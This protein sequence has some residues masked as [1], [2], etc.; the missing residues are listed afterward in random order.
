[1]ILEFV[2]GI[3]GICLGALL[4]FAYYNRKCGGWLKL[5]AGRTVILSVDPDNYGKFFE[6]KKIMPDGYL[7]L[8]D[9]SGIIKIDANTGIWLGDMD[10]KLYLHYGNFFRTVPPKVAAFSTFFKG[11]K[12]ELL[13]MTQEESDTL[14]RQAEN[15]PESIIF[16]L[17]DVMDWVHAIT[18][19]QLLEGALAAGRRYMGAK[20][21]E[22]SLES[23]KGM[24][25]LMLIL[26]VAL[27]PVLFIL[28]LVMGR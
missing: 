18:P 19:A 28:I 5:R 3:G 26:G 16:N 27:I 2:F 14:M 21:L 20:L 23:G 24:G 12:K 1:M 7:E 8:P 17:A 13:N 6:V 10:T 4:V 9:R 11:R 25:K 22:D 15:Q